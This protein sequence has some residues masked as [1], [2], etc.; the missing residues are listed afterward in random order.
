MLTNPF[1]IN[2]DHYLPPLSEEAE[3]TSLYCTLASTCPRTC[4]DSLEYVRSLTVEICK[5]VSGH[6]DLNVCSETRET[7]D[8]VL[9]SSY[10]FVVAILFCLCK[11]LP[12]IPGI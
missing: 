11:D 6:L 10:R 9:N 5:C 8:P 2:W 4:K 1:R 7:A 3:L 12:T